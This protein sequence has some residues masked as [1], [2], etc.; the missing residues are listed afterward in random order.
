MI[1]I[2][3]TMIG[4][5]LGGMA[6]LTYALARASARAEQ[7]AWDNARPRREAIIADQLAK[8]MAGPLPTDDDMDAWVRRDH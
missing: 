7:Q 4:G 8:N 3:L 1:W 2:I 5:I 6:L